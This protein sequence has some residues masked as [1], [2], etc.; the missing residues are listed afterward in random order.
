MNLWL[1][2]LDH[3]KN[4]DNQKVRKDRFER[5]V[6]LSLYLERNGR[7]VCSLGEK[8]GRNEGTVGERGDDD[9]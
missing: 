3:A 5:R 7:L 1:A 4:Q 9:E 6:C 2:R 8:E